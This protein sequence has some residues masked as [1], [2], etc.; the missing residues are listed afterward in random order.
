M[1]MKKRLTL[2]RHSRLIIT[3]GPERL[4]LTGHTVLAAIIKSEAA[5]K[6]VGFVSGRG[7]GANGANGD[8]SNGGV[9]EGKGAKR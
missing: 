5:H 9:G 4:T 1:R 2:I 8:A 3:L 6:S 7:V